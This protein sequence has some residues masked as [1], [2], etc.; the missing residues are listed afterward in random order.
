MQFFGL[1]NE[2]AGQLAAETAPTSHPTEDCSKVESRHNC[3]QLSCRLPRISL[4][5]QINLK[6]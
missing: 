3:R 4:K 5:N 6:V 2:E 1:H